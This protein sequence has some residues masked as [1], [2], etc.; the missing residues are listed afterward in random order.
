MMRDNRS[1]ERLA[2]DFFKR[3]STAEYAL[4][5]SGFYKKRNRHFYDADADWDSFANEQST[6][7]IVSDVNLR[8][9]VRF[10]LDNPPKKQVITMGVI[11]WAEITPEN[12]TDCQRLFIYIRRIRNNLFHGG[13]FGNGQW[14]E[15]Q[16]SRQLME[17]AIEIINES[18]IASQIVRDAYQ[19]AARLPDENE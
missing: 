17:A 4:K 14:F 10:I 18:M 13:K 19:L 6:I 2:F 12:M 5:V 8:N 15:P 3:F 7:D 9:S 16:R 11:D 1:I